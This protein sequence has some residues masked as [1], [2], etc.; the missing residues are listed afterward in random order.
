MTNQDHS[1]ADITHAGGVGQSYIPKEIT[2]MA[3]RIARQHNC[4]VTLSKESSGYHLYIPCPECLHTHGKSELK[5]PKYA[6]NLS[7]YFGIGDAFRHLQPVTVSGFSPAVMDFNQAVA[8]EKNFAT[9]ICMRTWQSANPHR[10]SVADL[11]VMGSVTSRH[12][13]I[14][15]SYRMVNQ[16][17]GDERE[18][19]WVEDPLSGKLCPPP[20]GEVIPL[21]ELSPTHP[22]RWYMETYRKFDVK[23]LVDLYRCGFCVKEYPES[24]V[25]KIW[26][27]PFP[28]GWKDTPQ[29]RIIFHALHGGSPMTWQGRWIEIVS[30]DG[31]TKQGLNPYTFQWD[32]MA[33][34]ATAKQAWIPH[35]PFDEVDA[36]GNLK[37]EISKYKTA[38]HS[39]RELMGWDSAISRADNDEDPVRWCVLTEGPLDSARVGAGGLAIMGKSIS[40][41][42]AEK[43]AA[44]FHVVFTAFDND[45]AGK[46]ATEKISASLFGC[47]SR[48]P[49]IVHVE[50]IV[51]PEGK[52]LGEM[53]QEVAD[54]IVATAVRAAKRKM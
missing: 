49:I 11:L 23:R 48:N 7:K 51:I 20:A 40:Q 30:Q 5:D 41:A 53:P 36:D 10:F 39:A 13:D 16:T 6:I 27:R 1:M 2:D 31:L 35:P 42:N 46:E 14:Y 15:T 18:S 54:K 33:T 44:N 28:G 9:G 37:F 25:H 45:R 3:D 34:R 17:D 19:H 22:A 50:Q 8:E 12:P 47:R 29:G 38:K 26:Y 24:K 43:V 4:K 21:T 52:D 32:V